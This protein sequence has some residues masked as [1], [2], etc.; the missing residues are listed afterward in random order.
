MLL[1]TDNAKHAI[2]SILAGAEDPDSAGL[3]ISSSEQAANSLALTVTTAPD[4]GDT[5]VDESGARVFLA[6]VAA[7]LL[8][9]MVLDTEAQEDGAVRFKVSRQP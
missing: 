3:R 4:D 7:Q 8:D 6:P 9:E 1:L 5:I 2:E